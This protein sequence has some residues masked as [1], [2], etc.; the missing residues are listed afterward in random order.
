MNTS[1]IAPLALVL[2]GAFCLSPALAATE[3]GH[4]ASAARASQPPAR[5]LQGEV[6]PELIGTKVQSDTGRTIVC[7]PPKP[8]TWSGYDIWNAFTCK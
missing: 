1:I 7:H 5:V 3:D 8:G 6:A 4:T 2:A